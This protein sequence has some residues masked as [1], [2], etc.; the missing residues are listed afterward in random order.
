MM[1]ISKLSIFLFS[2][3][4]LSNCAV[5]SRYVEKRGTLDNNIYYYEQDTQGE[6]ISISDNSPVD[7]EKREPVQ[8]PQPAL[9]D[10]DS[11][12]HILVNKVGL[13]SEYSSSLLS[14]KSEE[15]VNQKK[16]VINALSYL[17]KVVEARYKAIDAYQNKSAD[18][19]QV[20]K[21]AAD[22]EIFFI[23]RIMKIWPNDTS[24]YAQLSTAYD[25]PTY[26]RLKGFLKTQIESIEASDHAIEKDLKDR[27]VQLSLEAFLRSAGQ[28]DAVAI[29]LD[30]YDSIKQGALNK[31]NRFGLELSEADKDR[32]KQQMS[33]TEEMASTLEGLRKG[34]L[35]LKESWQKAKTHIAP[36]LTS[37]IED[38]EKLS[39]R[40]KP[41][42]MDARLKV[43]KDLIDEYINVIQNKNLVLYQA[44]R[45]SLEKD[46]D[47]LLNTVKYNP[48]IYQSLNNCIQDVKSLKSNWEN[49]THPSDII[50][51][52]SDSQKTIEGFKELQKGLSGIND[53]IIKEKINNIIESKLKVI[54][55]EERMVILESNEAKILNENI[56][57]YI[58]DVNDISNFIPKI[59]NTL[60]IIQK[61][62][63]EVNFPSPESFNVPLGD[64]KDTFIDLNY[65]PRE[66][67]DIITVKATLLEGT[68]EKDK[69]IATFQVNR[70][71]WYADLSP[72]VV[73]AKPTELKGGDDGFRFAP[74]LS[75]LHH[76][77]P[78]PND[79]HWY[80]DICRSIEPSIGIHSAFT[81]FS[82]G[83]SSE[84]I[85]IGLGM[86]LTFWKNRLQ[87]GGGYNLM[88]NSNDEGRIYYFVGSDLI[89]ILQTIGIVK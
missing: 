48:T 70:Y 23:S 54:S 12:I 87:F 42:T 81:N 47:D 82:T 73:L 4:L 57:G 9:V 16:A 80:A 74:V 46:K 22:I 26:V 18:F 17:Q 49:I 8:V 45:N 86:S 79:S 50:T 71:G 61:T 11:T 13:S 21:D 75:W 38:M 24:E 64:I 69:T 39:E 53:V 34:E 60:D 67:G 58:A 68:K 85:Q 41:E 59:V 76:W 89:G 31:T 78:R 77:V 72:A 3:M 65:T 35:T 19:S 43:T 27:Q 25:P 44:Q 14:N 32:L 6:K 20:K 1:K 56:K 84:N 29:H 10:M 7:A 63:I 55:D 52:V 36:E 28:Q 83:S 2:M 51:L 33:L 37:A 15:L 40:M 62:P 5:Q 88:A 66:Q 30:S